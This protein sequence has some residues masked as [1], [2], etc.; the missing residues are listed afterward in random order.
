MCSEPGCSGESRHL[1][2]IDLLRKKIDGLDEKI[3]EAVNERARLAQCI[4]R[5]KEDCDDSVYKPGREQVVYEHALENNPGPLPDEALK[6]VFREIISGCRS[7]EK[8]VAVAYLGPEGTFT[9]WAAESQ[10]GKSVDY[11][12]V[13]SLA[14]VFEDVESKRADYGVVPVENSTEGGIRETLAL[15]LDSSLKV[16]SEIVYEI[17][18]SLMARC[19]IEDVEKIYSKGPVFAQTRLW[20]RENL[21]DARRVEVESTSRAAR[22]AAEEESAAAIGF[23]ALARDCGLNLL[24]R[25]IQDRNDNV[26]RFFVL[27]NGISEPTGNDKTALLCSIKDRVGALHDLLYAFKKHGIN[28]TKIESFPSQAQAWHYLFFIDFMGHPEDEKIKTALKDMDGNCDMLKVLGA[29]PC[30]TAG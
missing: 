13:A 24:A 23:E 5:V 16:C 26:T 21:P 2:D 25:N 11:R 3:L 7:L 9:H 17:R 15:F 18:H 30:A 8:P 10:F 29:F 12:A 28:M 4:G 22:L 1:P 27:A 6:A 19:R 20:L 14:D